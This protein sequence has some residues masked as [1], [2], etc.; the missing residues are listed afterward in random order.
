MS[1]EHLVVC[2]SQD[3]AVR[4]QPRRRSS[5]VHKW[6]DSMIAPMPTVAISMT[7]HSAL[8]H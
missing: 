6:H 7:F 1:R 3:N 4:V 8:R 5:A 2:N